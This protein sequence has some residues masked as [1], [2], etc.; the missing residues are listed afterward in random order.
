MTTSLGESSFFPSTMST[1]TVLF[2]VA[3]SKRSSARGVWQVAMIP[4]W[5]SATRP[6]QPLPW[7]K[8]SHLSVAGSYLIMSPGPASM[9]TKF[10]KKKAFWLATQVGPSFQLY[11]T[12]KP[13]QMSLRGPV[14]GASNGPGGQRNTVDDGA[15]SPGGG[16]ASS[17]AASG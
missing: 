7:M 2:L 13:G 11:L 14:L 10:E 6:L 4:P 9:I 15:A 8:T 12:L 16:A 17:P 5:W 1:R 3:R